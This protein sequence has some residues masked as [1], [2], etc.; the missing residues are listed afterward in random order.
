[1]PTARAMVECRQCRLSANT[2]REKVYVLTTR[3]RQKTL[4]TVQW[5]E[6]WAAGV[7]A[8]GRGNGQRQTKKGEAKGVKANK[9]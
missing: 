6:E 8:S 9:Q 4:R 5:K 1:M 7:I 3:A 2:N